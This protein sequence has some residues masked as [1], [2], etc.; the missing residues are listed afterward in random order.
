MSD[1][2][3]PRAYANPARAGFAL[4]LVLLASFVLAGRGLGASG[5]FASVAGRVAG[6]HATSSGN[7]T[8]A[9]RFPLDV[10]LGQDWI[11]LELLGVVVGGFVSAW[12]SGRDATAAAS[13]GGMRLARALA[14][15]ACMGLGARLAY[16][17]TSGLALSGGA[18]MATGAWIFIPVTF[19]T[20]I[21]LTALTRRPV[22]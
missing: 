11:V 12:L 18:L 20:A 16:G 7:A 14:G 22:S 2:A 10:P 19:A 6:V 21:L 17:C 8:L 3:S 5:A 1:A 4:G 15:G 9:D 13:P